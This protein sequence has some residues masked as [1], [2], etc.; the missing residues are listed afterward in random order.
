M[1][2][3]QHLLDN[4]FQ[5]WKNEY[6]QYNYLKQYLKSAQLSATGWTNNDE[7][8]FTDLIDK[9]FYKVKQFIVFKINQIAEDMKPERANDLIKFVQINTTGFQKII[10]KH[11]KWTDTCLDQQL[12]DIVKQLDEFIVQLSLQ[13][14]WTTTRKYWVHPDNLTQVEAILLFNLPMKQDNEMTNTIYFDD[15]NKFS[16]YS[17]LLEQNDLAKVM[18]ARW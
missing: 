14:H 10:K 3:G 18:R 7:K 5:P 16:S 15:S 4:Q 12:A 13:Q 11:D 6:I 1:K 2:F 9:E 17:D 8:Y